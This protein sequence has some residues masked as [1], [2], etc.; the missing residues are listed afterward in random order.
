MLAVLARRHHLRRTQIDVGNA[1]GDVEA[2]LPLQAER[3]QREGIVRTANQQVAAEADADRSVGA[4]AAE[5]TG[6]IAA[7]DLIGRRVNGPGKTGLLGETKVETDTIDPGDVRFGATRR[8]FEN[9]LHFSAGSNDEA[10]VWATLAR[11]HADLQ[12]RLRVCRGERSD[13][14]GRADT[15]KFESPH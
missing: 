11:Q 12:L 10:D 4:N 3:L 13:Q 9:A 8:A 7:S 5:M 1:C 2:G 14:H 6:E 15:E